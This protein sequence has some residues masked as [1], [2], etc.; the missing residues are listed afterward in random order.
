MS[1]KKKWTIALGLWAFLMVVVLV[2]LAAPPPESGP[3]ASATPKPASVEDCFSPLDG[4]LDALEG[5]VR[6]L[7]LSPSSMRTHGTTF[8]TNP[9]AEGYHVVRMEYS[10]ENA[11]GVRLESVATGRVHERSC[12][13]LLV[14]PGL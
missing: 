12:R 2:V 13:T 4:N 7:L 8:S 5:L 11:F 3:A 14:D 1:R 10:A 6:P 9:D